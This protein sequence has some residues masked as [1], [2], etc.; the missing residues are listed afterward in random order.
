MSNHS[1]LIKELKFQISAFD[2]GTIKEEDFIQAIQE[3]Y[4]QYKM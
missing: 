1:E 3:I 2:N 4:E